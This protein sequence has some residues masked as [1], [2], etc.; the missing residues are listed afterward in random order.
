MSTLEN[1]EHIATPGR[2]SWS[3]RMLDVAC[4]TMA[5]Y[6]ASGPG[7]LAP[8]QPAVTRRDAAQIESGSGDHGASAQRSHSSYSKFSMPLRQV[9]WI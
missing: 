4:Q 9:F 7:S 2:S 5:N 3:R 1:I 6:T 8:A